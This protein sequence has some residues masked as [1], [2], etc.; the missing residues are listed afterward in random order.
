MNTSSSI[1]IS[2][3]LFSLVSTGGAG[4]DRINKLSERLENLQVPFHFLT[5]ITEKSRN[6]EAN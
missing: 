1:D 2:V 3:N 5:F 4:G 6:R